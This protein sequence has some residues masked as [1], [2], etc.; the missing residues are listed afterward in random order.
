MTALLAAAI[1]IN[2]MVNNN[3]DAPSDPLLG[4]NPCTLAVHA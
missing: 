4:T 3:C 2:T 1:F